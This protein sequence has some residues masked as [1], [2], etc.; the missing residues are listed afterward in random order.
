MC[1][2]YGIRNVVTW[3][4]S[5]YFVKSKTTAV[6]KSFGEHVKNIEHK[7]VFLLDKI[8]S[9]GNYDNAT[10]N[11]AYYGHWISDVAQMSLHLIS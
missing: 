9:T 2:P 11:I 8:D 3:S 6:P 10:V 5:T 1:S 4:H 7:L